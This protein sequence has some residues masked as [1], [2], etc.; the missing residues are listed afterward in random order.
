MAEHLSLTSP[1]NNG[2]LV[3]TNVHT[4][5][6]NG[7]DSSTGIFT[8]PVAG[9][10]SFNVQLCITYKLTAI[11]GLYINNVVEM[12]MIAYGDRTHGCRTMVYPAVLKQGNKVQ[13]KVIPGGSSGAIFQQDSPYR[14]NTFSGFLLR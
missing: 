5:V 14:M 13:A 12:K 11:D 6:G 10:Y 1:G 7:Y 3:F 4:N 2:P 9:T 8:A